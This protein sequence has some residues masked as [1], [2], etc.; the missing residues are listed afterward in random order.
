MNEL[1]NR[2][3]HAASSYD[4]DGVKQALD[5]GA[6][7]RNSKLCHV[8]ISPA[9]EVMIDMIKLLLEH[10]ADVNGADG[11]GFTALM[12]AAYKGSSELVNILIDHG[13]D[14]N[15]KTRHDGATALRFAIDSQ[16][17]E[18]I[19]I[20]NGYEKARLENESLQKAIIVEQNV[21]ENVIF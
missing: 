14:P 19:N 21:V 5:D 13:A 7:P 1:N 10:G 6:D 3:L 16:C 15:M 17:E 18:V 11:D 2:L 4:Y 9:Y 20:L 8:L 12:C